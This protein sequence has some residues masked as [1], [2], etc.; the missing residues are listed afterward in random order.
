MNISLNYYLKIFY[1]LHYEQFIINILWRFDILKY[2]GRNDIMISHI[3][4]V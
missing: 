2:K 1:L 4:F 3:L